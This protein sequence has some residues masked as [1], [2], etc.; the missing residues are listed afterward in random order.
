MLRMKT[1]LPPDYPVTQQTKA[2]DDFGELCRSLAVGK[3]I[4]AAKALAGVNRRV[5]AALEA[6]AAVAGGGGAADVDALVP[7]E[8]LAEAF[9][10]SLRTA[11]VFDRMLDSMPVFPL[12][13]RVAIASSGFTASQV[14]PGAAIPVRRMA[15]AGSTLDSIRVSG[16]CA[17]SSEL[18]RT[19]VAADLI[20]TELRSAVAAATDNVF[21][22]S[23]VA[24]TTPI[25]SSGNSMTD[26][27]ALANAV[28][29]GAD[30]QL[31]F[32]FGTAGG[33]ALALQRQLGTGS[34]PQPA[35]L[36]IWPTMGLTGGT[37]LDVPA[38]VSDQ[39]AAGVA[40]LVDASQIAAAPGE[41]E[42]DQST[43][44]DLAMADSTPMASLGGSPSS[45]TAA[46][47]V[48][49]FQTN[50]MAIKADRIFGFQLGRTTAVA[51][52]SGINYI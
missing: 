44:A 21:L 9:L 12:H 45:P 38:L 37:L 31:F 30:A 15:F 47:I 33:K 11:S 50:S 42:V 48:S 4:Y 40:L 18:A 26:L 16:I 2:L 10:A 49:M 51:S 14:A 3:D 52:L 1:F 22:A 41:I 6:K 43:Q 23:L 5:V 8:Q 32:V 39:L 29:Y 36:P 17:L 13:T 25:T 19:P 24:S 34:P 35:G 7:Y 27:A 28:S 20:N 46:T